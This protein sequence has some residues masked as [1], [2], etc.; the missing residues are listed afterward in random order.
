VYIYCPHK[1]VRMRN[2]HNIHEET[3]MEDV[4]QEHP[5]NICHPGKSIGKPLI[6]HE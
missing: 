5:K 2:V 3:T 4:G 1:E 6:K